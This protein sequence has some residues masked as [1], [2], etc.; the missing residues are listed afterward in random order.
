LK[1]TCAITHWF[2]VT[3]PI[4]FALACGPGPMEDLTDEP[5]L[6]EVGPIV[7]IQQTASGCT[8]YGGAPT[9]NSTTGKIRSAA[10]LTC[11]VEAVKVTAYTQLT[12]DGVQVDSEPNE[13]EFA[14]KCLAVMYYPNSSG[15]QEWCNI[16]SGTF[17]QIN[18]TQY[19]RNPPRCETS[20]F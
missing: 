19:Y 15:N 18:Y 3:S 8:L 7:S 10:L 9:Y 1:S 17:R 13:C 6:F 5:D 16:A 14:K 11:A 4:L 2:V 12:R 20:G